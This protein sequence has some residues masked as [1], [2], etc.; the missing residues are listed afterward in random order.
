MEIKKLRKELNELLNNVVSHSESFPENRPI[1]SLEISAVLSKIN[2][3]QEYLAVLKFLLEVQEKELKTY[4]NSH[5]K[6]TPL[7]LIYSKTKEVLNEESSIN[8]QESGSEKEVFVSEQVITSNI[9][10]EVNVLK[11][12]KPIELADKLKK[13][14]IRSLKDAFSLNDRYLYANELFNKNMEAFNSTVKKL[15]ECSS[16]TE[17]TTL[18]NTL[19]NE[20][21]WD[22]E[23]DFHLQFLELLERRF[24][25]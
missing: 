16:F 1:P 7:P 25:P 10:E 12:N 14:P 11:K 4:G 3:M 8:K 22:D 24:N 19:K 17:A 20:W 15:D 2:K 9:H 18:F 5:K 23:N 6:E 13:T 21:N